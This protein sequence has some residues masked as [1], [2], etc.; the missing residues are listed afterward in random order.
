ME[1]G[2]LQVAGFRSK[3]HTL[4]S[5][6]QSLPLRG[7]SRIS[8]TREQLRSSS[9]RGMTTPMASISFRRDNVE[10][11]GKEFVGVM[12]GRGRRERVAW[13]WSVRRERE[14]VVVARGG[15]TGRDTTARLEND[16]NF[17][18]SGWEK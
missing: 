7:R 8:S 12:V 9:G 11:R 10:E 1:N 6:H 5:A 16:T 17:A 14:S 2:D 18:G 13:I 15:N 4:V 3:H